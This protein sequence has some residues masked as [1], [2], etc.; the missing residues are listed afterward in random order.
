MK[1]YVLKQFYTFILDYGIA[2]IDTPMCNFFTLRE[3][4]ENVCILFVLRSHCW[5]NTRCCLCCDFDCD[6]CGRTAVLVLQV[7]K[8][9]FEIVRSLVG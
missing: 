3:G 1:N 5:E 6:I 7:L 4:C 8:F 2:L 9:V